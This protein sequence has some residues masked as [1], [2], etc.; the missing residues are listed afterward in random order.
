[1]KQNQKPYI[2][3]KKVMDRAKGNKTDRS[4]ASRIVNRLSK[5]T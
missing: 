4:K 1:M 2:M 5:N 3:K